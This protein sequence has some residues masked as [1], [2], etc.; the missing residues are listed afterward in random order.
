[1]GTQPVIVCSQSTFPS[2]GPQALG[3]QPLDMGP[4]RAD[5]SQ[6]SLWGTTRAR[7]AKNVGQMPCLNVCHCPEPESKAKLDWTLKEVQLLGAAGDKARLGSGFEMPSQLPKKL[8]ARTDKEEPSGPCKRQWTQTRVGFP[9]WFAALRLGGA[10]KGAI[11]SRLL[12]QLPVKLPGL[13]FPIKQ[14]CKS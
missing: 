8:W 14:R 1:M 7:L 4:H 3:T 13:F 12:P 9:A 5:I 10:A 11:T 2:P 6:P